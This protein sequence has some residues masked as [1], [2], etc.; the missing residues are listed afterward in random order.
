MR[1]MYFA[2]P[3]SYDVL[4]NCI[5]LFDETQGAHTLLGTVMQLFSTAS[6]QCTLVH[7]QTCRWLTLDNSAGGL[8]VP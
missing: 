2:W 8:R 7:G 5:K 4:L 3:N 1:R 6:V